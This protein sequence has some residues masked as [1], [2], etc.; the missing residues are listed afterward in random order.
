MPSLQWVVKVVL[1]VV[2]W[3]HAISAMGSQGSAWSSQVGKPPKCYALKA[4]H[5][6]EVNS[7]DPLSKKAYFPGVIASV[8]K[9]Y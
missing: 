6:E 2:K 3:V 9:V 8:V 5:W 7:S 4:I 1:G